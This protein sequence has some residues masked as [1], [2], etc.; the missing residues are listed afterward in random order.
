MNFTESR[1]AVWGQY[2]RPDTTVG[3][4]TVPLKGNLYSS[5]SKCTR[6]SLTD[7]HS[8]AGHSR[9]CHFIP[10]CQTMC[11]LRLLGDSRWHCTKRGHATPCQMIP[12]LVQLKGPQAAVF[13]SPCSRH[14][15]DER[16]VNPKRPVWCSLN[17]CKL[18]REKALATNL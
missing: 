13:G 9:T 5:R 18:L 14:R 4:L 3:V 8:V 2:P 15:H 12:Q 1:C 7:S 10:A 6:C 16:V 17:D 11:G